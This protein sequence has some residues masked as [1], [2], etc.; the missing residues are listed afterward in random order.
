MNEYLIEQ[1]VK[2][3][4]TEKDIAIKYGLISLTVLFL[5]LSL[6]PIFLLLFLVLLF[7]DYYVLRRMDVEFEY[8]YFEGSIDIA[9][10][11]NKQFRKELFSTNIKE[12]V[13]IVAPSDHDALSCHQVDKTLN[14][15]SM[16]PEKKTYTMITSYKEKKVK[17]IFEP[18]EKML[19]AMRD[20]APRKVIF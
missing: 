8:T 2:K 11:M 13:E 5:L 19:N 14:Y 1:L 9:K 7:V 20:I 15:S 18:N 12:D 17:I 10:V 6:N 16:I 3:R 4:T